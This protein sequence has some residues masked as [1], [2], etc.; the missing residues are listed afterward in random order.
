MKDLTKLVNDM[1]A[2]VNQD[3][4]PA[5][6]YPVELPLG[7]YC[8]HTVLRAYTPKHIVR[9]FCKE[10]RD[11]GAASICVNPVHVKLVH[12][13]LKGTDIKT[14]CVIGFPLGANLP[15][16][17]ALEA[18]LAIEDGADE[19]DMVINIG[20]LRDKDYEAVYNDI[21]AV[22]DAAAGKAHVKVIIE[23]CYL[24]REEKI[25]A[26]VLSKEAGADYVKTST[27]MGN[28]GATVEDVQL[29][30]RV[31]GEDMKVKASTGSMNRDDVIA[32]VKAGAVR[33]G[34]SRLV[35][36]DTGDNDAYCASKDNQPPKF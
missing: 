28:G 36:I 10:G 5:R 25:A 13:E 4:A 30:K 27:G 18:K 11:H 12:E 9:Q 20:S 1:I 32:M 7:K 2:E 17:K 19:V 24:T 35:Q 3:T 26:C 21:K 16:V 22:V 33:M 23:T 29:M 14:C 8:D 15:E 34:T 31:V 6:E